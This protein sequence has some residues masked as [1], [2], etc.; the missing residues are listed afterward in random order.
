MSEFNIEVEGGKAVRLPTAGK[1]C[2]RDIVVT[3]TGG[4]SAAPMWLPYITSCQYMF[5]GVTFPENTELVIE[6]QTISYASGFNYMFHNAKNVTSVK[7]IVH[8]KTSNTCVY[9]FASPSI[10]RVDLSEFN[11]NVYNW[12]NA[13]YGASALEE[14]IG[15]IGGR[16]FDN[17]F[18]IC[19][20]LREVRFAAGAVFTSVSFSY[21]SLLS[22]VSIQSII[23][24]LADLTGQTAQTL[25][26]HATVGAKLTQAQKDA[27]SAK[28]WTLV[29]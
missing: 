19:Y 13:F 1:Y 17:A 6:L 22:D 18:Y 15:E 16:I 28:N 3:A 25:T 2:D 5:S 10:Q 27:V 8:N 9:G 4:G 12:T 21:S 7:L 23:D 24:G 26:L 14:I 11:V 20:E 29:Y